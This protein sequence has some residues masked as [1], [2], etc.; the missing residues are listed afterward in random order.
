MLNPNVQRRWSGIYVEGQEIGI[1]LLSR[2][3]G[4]LAVDVIAL[5]AITGFKEAS[6]LSAERRVDCM[7]H[8]VVVSDARLDCFAA[9]HIVPYYRSGFTLALEPGMAQELRKWLPKL[10]ATASVSKAV[11]TQFQK[12]L[13][14]PIFHLLE[15][16]AYV[17]A[18]I[19][20]D[21]WTVEDSIAF[22]RKEGRWKGETA[23]M[24]QFDSEAVRTL[25]DSAGVQAAAFEN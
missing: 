17:V 13:S 1:E 22:E 3:D 5:P 20:L 18:R 9:D 7:P 21:R 19:I 2:A 10:T 4:T 8:E 16:I 23:F 11:A 6:R 14:E 12:Q 25:L 24:N 15:A